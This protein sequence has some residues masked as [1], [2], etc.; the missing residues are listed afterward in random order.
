MKVKI[1]R[2]EE[3][4]VL[5]TRKYPG[6]AGYDLYSMYNY[7]FQPYATLLVPLGIAIEIPE[8]YV[9]IIKEKSGLPFH[10]G[11]GVIDSGYRGQLLVKVRNMTYRTQFINCKSP[12]AQ[13][14]ILSCLDFEIEEVQELS[15][16]ERGERGGINE[17]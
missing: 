8:G 15:K 4:A 5:P 6:D 3:K 12:I 1:K 9:G 14:L 2:L 13:L 7:S 16:T 10:I 11:A 17:G